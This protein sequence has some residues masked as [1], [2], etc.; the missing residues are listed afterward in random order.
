METAVGHAVNSLQMN[1]RKGIVTK[2]HW[3]FLGSNLKLLP[4]Y[5]AWQKRELQSIVYRMFICIEEYIW[6]LLETKCYYGARL[7]AKLGYGACQH[8]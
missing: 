2:Y 8:T 5:V 1:V 3:T 7:T 4:V 6:S